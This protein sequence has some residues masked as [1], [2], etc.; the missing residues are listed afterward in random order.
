VVVALANGG[1]LAHGND[2]SGGAT[3]TLMPGDVWDGMSWTPLTVTRKRSHHRG[4]LLGDDDVLLVGGIATN[5]GGA[6]IS[7]TADTYDVG[8]QTFTPTAGNLASARRDAAAF[9]TNGDAVICGGIPTVASST[10]LATCERYNRMTRTFSA[11]GSLS[12]ARDDSAVVT[13][14][15][16]TSWVIGG[17]GGNTGVSLSET[18]VWDGAAMAAG[19]SLIADRAFP[20]ACALRDGRLVVAGGFDPAAAVTDLSSVEVYTP[21]AWTNPFGY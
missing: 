11:A 13:F 15:D 12:V 20:A 6:I 9:P 10:P 7:S 17:G 8:T 3:G 5:G 2:A 4:V 19:P 16:G 14:P 18:D 1:V 21:P